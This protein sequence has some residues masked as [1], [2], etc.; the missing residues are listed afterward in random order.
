MVS[1]P[2]LCSSSVSGLTLYTHTNRHN[3]SPI[4]HHYTH[5]VVM[6]NKI[7]DGHDNV[8]LHLYLGPLL[9]SF[10]HLAGEGA[11]HYTK[12]FPHPSPSSFSFSWCSYIERL[13]NTYVVV[14]WK[15][16][17]SKYKQLQCKLW[18]AKCGP[19]SSRMGY[20][21]VQLH[22]TDLQHVIILLQPMEGRS[23]QN[24]TGPVPV[25]YKPVLTG[26]F[27]VGEVG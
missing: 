3:S 22:Q 19:H 26:W 4:A 10:W 23:G 15:V 14:L 21:V 8:G 18:N 27:G 6:N 11:L 25:H 17:L 7:P 16:Q 13:R 12:H 2:L 24:Q 1:S 5:T 20:I 9:L